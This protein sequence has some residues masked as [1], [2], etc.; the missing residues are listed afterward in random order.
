MNAF[1]HLLRS[2]GAH[3]PVGTWIMSASP[4]VAEALGC[5]GFDWAV[6]DMEHAPIDMWNT[7][8]RP[9]GGPANVSPNA[10][11]TAGRPAEAGDLPPT[12]IRAE[13]PGLWVAPPV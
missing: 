7:A 6:V 10:P 13:D 4:L 8:G 3:P 5:A 12:R 11:A 9:G 2:A 1:E